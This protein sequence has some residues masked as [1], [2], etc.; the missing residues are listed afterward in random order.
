M[1]LQVLHLMIDRP[2]RHQNNGLPWKRGFI[3][4]CKLLWRLADIDRED[5]DGARISRLKGS[6]AFFLSG[7]E[8]G[9]CR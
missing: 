6:C 3:G 2:P 5:L 1:N 9:Y 4:I 8:S 7:R